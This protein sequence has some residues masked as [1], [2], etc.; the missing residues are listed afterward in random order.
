MPRQPAATL[1]RLAEYLGLGMLASFGLI[2]CAVAFATWQ[3]TTIRSAEDLER[4]TS[5]ACLDAIPRLSPAGAPGG[6]SQHP[7]DAARAPRKAAGQFEEPA[8]VYPTSI[9][10]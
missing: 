5:A 6:G 4:L 1:T 7:A 10:E 3:D 9:T 8:T 2:L